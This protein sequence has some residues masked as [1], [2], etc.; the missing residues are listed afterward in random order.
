[1]HV[2]YCDGGT[3]G[4][5]GRGSTGVYWSI[6]NE[7]AGQFV[8]QRE[9]STA[10]TT[11]SEAEYCA[12]IHTLEHVTAAH[13]PKDAVVI[14]MDSQFVVRQMYGRYRVRNERLKP[15][16]MRAKALWDT[17]LKNDMLVA[18]HWVSR[19]ETSSRLHH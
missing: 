18:I 9:C 17:L 7:T 2:Y 15:L 6:Y 8:V 16:Y 3:I 10:Y 14:H 12:L 19:T 4:A 5:N 1:M 13:R 11:N